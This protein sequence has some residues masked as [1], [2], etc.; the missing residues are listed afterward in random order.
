[1]IPP[2]AAVCQLAADG[3]DPVRRARHGGEHVFARKLER[4]VRWRRQVQ[5]PLELLAGQ[6]LALRAEG[7][8]FAAPVVDV[9]EAEV[10]VAGLARDPRSLQAY[11]VV[12]AVDAEV[13]KRALGVGV[14]GG[15]AEKGLGSRN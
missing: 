7:F 13:L 8:D 6:Q 1:L 5:Q 12:F 14:V 15:V 11:E 3:S 9:L 2:V 4:L 10:K